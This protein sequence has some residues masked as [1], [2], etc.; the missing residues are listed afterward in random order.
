VARLDIADGWPE[1]QLNRR[2]TLQ[3]V[4][5]EDIPILKEVFLTLTLGRRSLKIWIFIA[6][7]TEFILGLNMLRQ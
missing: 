3:T 5:G 7:I 2:F 4:S 6:D 1:R